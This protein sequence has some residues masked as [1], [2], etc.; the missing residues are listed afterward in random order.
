MH[1]SGRRQLLRQLDLIAAI[2]LGY[3]QRRIGAGD[4]G[5]QIKVILHQDHAKTGGDGDNPLIRFDFQRGDGS[6]DPFGNRATALLI[7]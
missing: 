3:I 7:G 4:A 5:V 2:L 6:P 1:K